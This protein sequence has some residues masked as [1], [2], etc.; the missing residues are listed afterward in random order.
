MIGSTWQKWD[1][2]IHSPL[3]HLNNHFTC[4]MSGYVSAL[5]KS[6]LALVGITNYFYFKQNEL[7]IIRNS[8]REAARNLAVLGNIEFRITQPNNQGEWINM[9]CIFSE[10]LSTEQINNVLAT[11]PLMNTS[12]NGMTVYCSEASMHQNGVSL[13]HAVVDYVGLCSHLKTH[14]RYGID[15]LIGI[16]PN[17]YGGFRPT[18]N[19]GRSLAIAYE[20]EKKGDLIFGSNSQTRTFFLDSNRFEGAISKPVLNCSDAHSLEEVGT[21]YSWIKARPT[22]EGL[23]QVLIEPEERVQIIDNFIERTFIKPRFQSIKAKGTVFDSQPLQFSDTT[24]FLNPNMVSIIGGR[25]T[26]KS[27]LLD[28]I[29]SKF[30]HESLE[31]EQRH[32]NIDEFSLNLDQGDGNIIAFTEKDSNYDYLHVSQGDIQRISQNP[33]QLSDEIKRMLGLHDSIF[34]PIIEESTIYALSRYRSFINYWLAVDNNGNSINTDNHQNSIIQ[35]YTNL[36]RT[37]TSPQN[38]NLIERYQNNIKSINELNSYVNSCNKLKALINETIP[39]INTDIANINSNRLSTTNI[40][41]LDYSANMKAIEANIVNTQQSLSRLTSDNQSIVV[42][43]QRQ[44]INQDISSLLSKVTDYQSQIDAANIKLEEIKRKTAEYQSDVIRRSEIANKYKLFLENEVVQVNQA[45]QSLAADNPTWNSEQNLLVK[46]ILKDISIYGDICFDIEK[47]LNGLLERLNRGKFRGTNS[48]ST[49]ERL[50]EVFPIHTPLD[51]FNLISNTE[52]I[53]LS[54]KEIVSL[55][56]FCWKSEYFNQSGRFDLLDYLYTPQSIKSFLY[57]NAE[58]R[59][60]DKTVDKLSVGQRGTFY[61]CLKLAT[62]PF[63]SPFIFDQPE[64]DLDNDF[65]MHNLVPLFRKI[66][67]YRQVIIVTHNAN[68]VVNSDS[69]QVIVAHNDNEIL[70]YFSGAVEDGLVSDPNSM[71]SQI[72]NILEGGGYAFERR[73]KKYGLHSG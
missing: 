66:K 33:D 31:I 37:L 56:S 41:M 30:R 54:D 55:E 39:L 8:I 46:D 15:Y 14:L 51:F 49:L 60:K 70:T 69:E 23:R 19:V 42:E 48:L 32:V 59:Y 47:F 6:D 58:F 10:N 9:H 13:E 68:L 4:A 24:L 18:Q 50:K 36:I 38:K 26:G 7:E 62:D 53:V 34:D 11:M 61:V 35:N 20:M 1:L 67:K 64:D 71:R 43:F 73:E 12:T 52:M 29:R 21:R 44:G 22:F 63:G 5:I 72:C 3:T 40:L 28:A 27:I 17:G 2:H 25:G 57:V 45:F 65:I 16:C